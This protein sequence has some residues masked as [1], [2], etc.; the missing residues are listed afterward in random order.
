MAD[1]MFMCPRCR[2]HKL[3]TPLHV[4]HKNSIQEGG[5]KFYIC[6]SC[7]NEERLE[8]SNIIPETKATFTFKRFIAGIKYHNDR[9]DK[10]I[11][12]MEA[13]KKKDIQSTHQAYDTCMALTELLKR[14]DTNI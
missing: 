9:V 5:E 4:W 13:H 7:E 11:K 6:T 10:I 14:K 12:T 1:K 2:T 8:K 3:S